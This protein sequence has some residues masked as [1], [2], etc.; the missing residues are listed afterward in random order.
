[1]NHY[2]PLAHRWSNMQWLCDWFW[3]GSFHIGQITSYLQSYDWLYFNKEVKCMMLC[4][5]VNITKILIIENFVC[6]MK[7]NDNATL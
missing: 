6:R 7:R 4:V 1:M 3:S 2:D 5:S